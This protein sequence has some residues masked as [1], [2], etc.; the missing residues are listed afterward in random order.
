M[1]DSAQAW[2]RRFVSMRSWSPELALCAIALVLSVGALQ[3]EPF[4]LD[5][6]VAEVVKAWQ[7]PLLDPVLHGVSAIG[8]FRIAAPTTIVAVIVVA[9]LGLRWQAVTLG[10][11]ALTG[12]LFNQLLKALIERPR[13]EMA[14]ERIAELGVDTFAFPSGHAQ[15]F[16]IFYGF[17][18]YLIWQH[19]PWPWLRWLGVTA[20][21]MMI[22]LVGISRVYLGV[23]WPS[24]V[25]GAYTIGILWVLLW[26]RVLRAGSTPMQDPSDEGSPGG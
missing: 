11:A 22:V 10:V 4:P 16:T 25:L 2:L 5:V 17:L 1:V 26:T 14:A 15:S 24:D 20:A 7:F 9:I 12:H 8:W 23:H 19:V 6:G 21:L 13:P 3:G 18:A